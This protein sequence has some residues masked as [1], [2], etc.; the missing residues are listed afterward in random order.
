MDE[1]TYQAELSR[2]T[3]SLE[4]LGATP[5]QLK[6]IQTQSGTP[7]ERLLYRLIGLADVLEE[8]ANAKD[9]G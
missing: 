2:I 5:K 3:K 1:Q 9:N 4:R 7:R 8:L 6:P